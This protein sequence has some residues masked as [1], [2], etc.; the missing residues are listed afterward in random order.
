MLFTYLTAGSILAL[1]ADVNSRVNPA[2]L[3]LGVK[4]LVPDP[5]VIQRLQIGLIVTALW[6]LG[7]VAAMVMSYYAYRLRLVILKDKDTL[8]VTGVKKE[9]ISS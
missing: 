5:T 9:E 7:V 2:P 8:L 6:P 4:D 3:P 1:I